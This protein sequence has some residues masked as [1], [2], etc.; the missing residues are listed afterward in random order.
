MKKKKFQ[1]SADIPRSKIKQKL[2]KNI[3]DTYSSLTISKALCLEWWVRITGQN[4]HI[5]YQQNSDKTEL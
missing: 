3:Y 1:F 2:R 5:S 4:L